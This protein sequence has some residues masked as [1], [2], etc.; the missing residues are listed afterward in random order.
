MWGKAKAGV[1]GN[2][3][4]SSAGNLGIGSLTVLGAG[5]KCC[6]CWI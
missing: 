4:G 1:A 3:T 6:P 5:A 2:C